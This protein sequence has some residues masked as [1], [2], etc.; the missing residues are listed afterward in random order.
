MYGNNINVRHL[1]YDAADAVYVSH[2]NLMFMDVIR[3]DF[4]IYMCVVKIYFAVQSAFLWNG[5]LPFLPLPP[6]QKIV[7][8]Q[9]RNTIQKQH[10]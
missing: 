6:K 9:Q 3:D 10:R 4:Y 8:Q 5:I 1:L 2:V 7:V